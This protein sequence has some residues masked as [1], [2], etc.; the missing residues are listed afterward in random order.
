MMIMMRAGST[1]VDLLKIVSQFRVTKTGHKI[2]L[3]KET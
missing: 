2:A 1:V 3:D